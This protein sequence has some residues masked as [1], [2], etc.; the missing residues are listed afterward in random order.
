MLSLSLRE[1]LIVY[2]ACNPPHELH[3]ALL[4]PKALRTPR[5]SVIVTRFGQGETMD[6]RNARHACS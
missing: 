6:L 2:Y 4:T 1:T 3:M 5:G